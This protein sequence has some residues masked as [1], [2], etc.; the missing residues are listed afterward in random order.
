MR[1]AHGHG[2]YFGPWGEVIEHDT[3]MCNHCNRHTRLKPKE[4]PY[5]TCKSCMEFI[6]EECYGKLMKGAQCKPLEQWLI[7]QE[8]AIT[9]A[10]ERQGRR[11]EYGLSG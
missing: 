1:D 9:R 10:V 11:A 4:A 7:E 3:Y 2:V 6:C 5:A 8:T